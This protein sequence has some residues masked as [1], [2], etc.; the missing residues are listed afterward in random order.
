ME[1]ALARLKDA[2]VTI[3]EAEIPR[4]AELQGGITPIVVT[5]EIPRNIPKFLERYQA[6]VTFDALIA[7]ASP[8]VSTGLKSAG[9]LPDS[10][11]KPS[12]DAYD[13]AIHK[14]RPAL[15]ETYRGYFRQYDVAAI[16]FPA[17]RMPAPKIAKE[18]VSPAPDI[19]INGKMVPGRAAFGRN[20]SPSST[21]GL[22]GL[23]IPAGLTPDGLL[24]GLELDGPAG[25]DG[26]LLALGL[27]VEAAL[28]PIPAPK[29]S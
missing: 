19:E 5:Y 22:P 10:P 14:L 20:I 27:A 25:S 13:N 24:V 1:Q 15:Q 18:F 11:N 29:A 21:A 28:G 17:L 8:D 9:A 12:D 7:A 16:V 23:V 4:L 6:P 3:V 2:G 26:E